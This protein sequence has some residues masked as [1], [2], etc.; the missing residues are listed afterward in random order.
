VLLSA[1][2]ACVAYGIAAFSKDGDWIIDETKE[3]CRAVRAVLSA[4]LAF[5]RAMV[6]HRIDLS[7][8]SQQ[9]DELLK[10][11]ERYLGEL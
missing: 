1:G 10:L 2:E 6:G 8:F 9:H 4:G 5:K 11:A 3:S 7:R